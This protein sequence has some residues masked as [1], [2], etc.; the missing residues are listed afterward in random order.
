MINSEGLSLQEERL[1]FDPQN[2]TP[3][4]LAARESE[5]TGSPDLDG[6]PT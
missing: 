4:T 5:T 6:Q 1:G 2:W 3:C